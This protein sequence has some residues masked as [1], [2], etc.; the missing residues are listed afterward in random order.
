MLTVDGVVLG[1]VSALAG[2]TITIT[3]GTFAAA[4]YTDATIAARDPKTGQTRIGGDTIVITGG[5]GPTSP[6]VVYGDTSQDG[7]WYSGDPRVQSF[8]S[9]GTKP[10]PAEIGNGDSRFI[11][12]V[13][14]PFTYAGHDVID[15]VGPVRRG[16]LRLA[17]DRRVHRVR[18]RG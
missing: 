12:P 2:D 10:Y 8:R 5:A 13:A 3:G 14:N 7:L 11:F 15:A 1:T 6:L 4:G 9:F 16:R 18:R 17:P